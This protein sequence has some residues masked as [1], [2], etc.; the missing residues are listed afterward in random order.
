M[1]EQPHLSLILVPDG[2]RD[3]RT[4]RIP[5]SLLR[6]FALFGLTAAVLVT[7]IV[8]VGGTSQRVL[9]VSASLRPG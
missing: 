9:Y 8:G 1:E 6:L 2:A 4:F 5:Y 3:S 7:A